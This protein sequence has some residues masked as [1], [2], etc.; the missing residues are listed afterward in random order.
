V[1]RVYA[2][3]T[4]LGGPGAESRGYRG[5]RII[6]DAVAPILDAGMRVL[7]AGCGAGRL[8][9]AIRNRVAVL[10]GL[11]ISER[12]T[13]QARE[14]KAY[15][16]LETADLE[17]FLPRH[18]D[19]YD[20]I[21]L[22]AVLVHYGDLSGILSL[23]RK[24]LRAD[25]ALVFTTFELAGDGARNFGTTASNFFAHG[26]GYLEQSLRKA[27]FDTISIDQAIHEYHGDD[28]RMCHIV[29]AK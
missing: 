22:A 28:P 4:F 23:L 16:R 14:T 7:D 20:L 12:M 11:D 9:L 18:R 3:K 15:D 24:S 21:I 19:R 26:A 8:G 10:E 25:G 13:A 29:T 5:H 2:E 6:L 17:T 1:E 27:A